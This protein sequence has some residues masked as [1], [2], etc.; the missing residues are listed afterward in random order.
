IAAACAGTRLPARARF[1]PAQDLDPLAGILG[2]QEQPTRLR[3][4]QE[5]L[6]RTGLVQVQTPQVFARDLLVRAY[7]QSD[8][9]STDD[10][11]LVERLGHKVVVV[12]GDALNIKITRP[13]DL[14]L[15]RAILN[16][17][18]PEDRPAHMRF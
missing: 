13:G 10:A 14:A 15:A 3:I 7:A 1:A 18:G 4:I 5:T 12:E 8:L 6:D 17:K 16:V 2:V 9:T 11:S